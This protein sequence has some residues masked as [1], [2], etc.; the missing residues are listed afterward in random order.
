MYKCELEAVWQEGEIVL[1]EQKILP[2]DKYDQP[3]VVRL[4]LYPASYTYDFYVRP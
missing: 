2:F 4:R 1:T 3:A